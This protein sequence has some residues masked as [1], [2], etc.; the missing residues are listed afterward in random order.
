MTFQG[1]ARCYLN[2]N[3]VYY[4]QECLELTFTSRSAFMT[5]L[6]KPT[7]LNTRDFVTGEVRTSLLTILDWVE[8]DANRLPL[9]SLINYAVT[10]DASTLPTVSNVIGLLSDYSRSSNDSI[11]VALW[12][13][14]LDILSLRLLQGQT[15]VTA[16]DFAT[17]G[18]SVSGATFFTLSCSSESGVV[19]SLNSLIKITGGFTLSAVPNEAVA[20]ST[21]DGEFWSYP[22]AALIYS[23]LQGATGDDD[24][25]TEFS[26][27]N[28]AGTL[29]FTGAA[30]T[31]KSCLVDF[32][33]EIIADPWLTDS[34]NV[35]DYD[36]I[37]DS[38]CTNLL[39]DHITSPVYLF[40]ICT[41]GYSFE[42][43]STRCAD[44]PAANDAEWDLV[45]LTL[46]A[47]SQASLA[48]AIACTTTSVSCSMCFSIFSTEVYL[49]VPSAC[50]AN[51][52]STEFY[53]VL[54]ATG[55]PLDHFF[56]CSG[57]SLLFIQTST[58]PP[59]T[60]TTTRWY[61]IPYTTCN[62][63]VTNTTTT[64]TTIQTTTTVETTTK[65]CNTASIPLVG[66]VLILLFN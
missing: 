54:N 38:P 48:D 18:C 42:M 26:T 64:T 52:G 65:A 62:P 22:Y 5:G 41:G 40:E 16:F 11:S 56:F 35:C 8:I 60:H 24:R 39:F 25:W 32:M 31:C 28:A 30:V 12:K 17:K 1:P 7:L 29:M 53:D 33:N 9:Q 55:G 45:A 46:C 27:V 10:V 44:P 6:N 2:T 20:C 57:Q 21:I 15:G 43:T 23:V 59:Q 61:H 49:N 14:V 19:A 4:T 3:Y 36:H 63:D 37:L 13:F 34:G 58:K 66:L 50:S 47:L 51:A